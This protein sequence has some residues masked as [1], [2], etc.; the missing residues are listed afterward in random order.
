MDLRSL[1]YE[2]V[3][4]IK[5]FYNKS[6]FHEKLSKEKN[7]RIKSFYNSTIYFSLGWFLYLSRKT[8]NRKLRHEN[9][10]KKMLYE[11]LLPLGPVG[12]MAASGKIL[13]G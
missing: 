4:N 10:G 2:R 12:I 6:F 9:T 8:M 1:M 5:Q 7:S 13:S 3:P 11:L